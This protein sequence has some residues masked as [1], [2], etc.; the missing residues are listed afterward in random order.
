MISLADGQSIT[1]IGVSASSLTGANFVFDQTPQMANSGTITI[2]IGDGAL[3][4]V[5]G[6]IDNLG[7]ISIG[8]VGAATVLQLIQYGVT[9]QGGGQVTL[10]DNDAN[11]I[12]ATLPGVSL[13]NVDN[14]ISG[15]GQIGNGSLTLINGGS[16]VANGSH[17]LVIDTGSNTIFNSGTIAA[18][19]SGGLELASGLNNQGSIL[20]SAS[21]AL[22]SGNV[23]GS[24]EVLLTGH[25]SVEFGAAAS[26]DIVL[27]ASATALITFD[28]S[29][30]FSG[31]ITGFDSD[32]QVQLQDILFGSSTSLFW[33]VKE[34]GS[35]GVLTVSDGEHQS[36]IEFHG[37]YDA[38]LFTIDS[39]G[40]G[41]TQVTYGDWF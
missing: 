9:L 17:A 34:D 39:N 26:S 35:G 30:D 32:D 15:A 37:N 5:S 13:N 12:S 28:D 3:L 14:A 8:S 31:T 20:V 2:T 38:S 25:A 18:T 33:A 23:S 6:T 4:P 21:H 36:V 16:I 29:I 11:V 40:H 22:L 27:G 1:L 7:T 41:G 24:G 19:A 10:S